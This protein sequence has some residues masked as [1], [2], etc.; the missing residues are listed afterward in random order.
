MP[1]H[2][3][4]CVDENVFQAFHTA[5]IIRLS[6][7]LNQGM[8]PTAYY[9]LAEQHGSQLG[10]DVVR[11]QGSS[12]CPTSRR[13]LSIRQLGGHQLVALVEIVS[14]ANK[15]RASDVQEF[16]DKAESALS[17][18]V[19]LLLVDLF[20]P[21]P[22]DPRGLPA[23]LCERLTQETAVMSPGQLTLASYVA[24]KQPQVYLEHMAVGAPLKPMPLFYAPDHSANA[25]LEQSYMAAFQAM[26]PYWR[27]AF[28]A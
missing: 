12:K 19:N 9:A 17:C 22:H 15:A 27:K 11:L 3:W 20:P 16:L 7:A 26:P 13:T 8:M 25:P 1:V 2:D 28:G 18:G 10:A 14:P 6:A 5:W 23:A 4:T 24:G 21:G